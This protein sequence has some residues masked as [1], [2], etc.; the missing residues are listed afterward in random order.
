MGVRASFCEITPELFRRLVRGE[1]PEIP[2]N[3][4]HSIDKAWL[5][6]HSV[7]S[8]RGYPLSLVVTGDRLHPQSPQTFEDFCKGEYEWYL[9]FAS[10]ELVRE[11]AEAL[12]GISTSQLRKWYDEHDCGGYDLEFYLFSEL[13]S[14][15]AGAAEYGNALMIL[16]A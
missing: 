8:K 3:N 11:A 15:Y 7:F 6:F 5:D 12:S 13:Q 10:P 16:V 9:G 2:R 14:A 1:E 4:R